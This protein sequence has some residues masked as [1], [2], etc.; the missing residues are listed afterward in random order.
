[1]H[2]D[3]ISPEKTLYS[4]IHAESI[5]CPGIDGAF[6]LLDHHA[7]IISALKNGKIE[8]RENGNPIVFEI[9]SGMVECNKNKVNVL[10]E[11]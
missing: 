3:I 9:K 2:I 11:E 4:S 10:I 6:Q 5:T 8:V 7:P 1:M